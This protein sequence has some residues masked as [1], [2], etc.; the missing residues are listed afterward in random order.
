MYCRGRMSIL[1]S[2]IIGPKYGSSD[3]IL[4]VRKRFARSTAVFRNRLCRSDT[5]HDFLVILNGVFTRHQL[6]SSLSK[7]SHSPG[8]RKEACR[9]YSEPTLRFGNHNPEVTRKLLKSPIA[10][11][12][13]RAIGRAI[14]HYQFAEGSPARGFHTSEYKNVGA[15][16]SYNNENL[17]TRSAGR[18]KSLPEGTDLEAAEE[19]LSLHILDQIY[20]NGCQQRQ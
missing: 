12:S 9:E 8:P 2:Y 15:S 5:K 11:L 17:H 7:A 18:F 16:A 4:I 10:W 20:S 3:S 1:L 13:S 14:L 6:I 19:Q